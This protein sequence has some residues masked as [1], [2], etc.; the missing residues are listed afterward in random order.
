MIE[1]SFIDTNVLI[2]C[3]VEDSSRT[4]R[5][6]EIVEQSHI[7]STQVFNEYARILLEKLRWPAD[8]V[9][10][11]LRLVEQRLDIHQVDTGTAVFAVELGKR[12]KFSWWDALIVASALEADCT[13]LWT[14]DMQD[15]LLVDDRLTIRN[16]F[17]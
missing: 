6:D 16:P 5:A 2:Y 15:G 17:S 7:A 1:K 8:D 3:H 13:T 4:T 9:L 10:V 14:E 11:A 12:Y